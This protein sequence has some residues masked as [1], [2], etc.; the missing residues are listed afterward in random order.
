MNVYLIDLIRQEN[1]K[2]KYN[3][4]NGAFYF[5]IILNIISFVCDLIYCGSILLVLVKN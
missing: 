4:N 5:H 3:Q 1:C 2:P